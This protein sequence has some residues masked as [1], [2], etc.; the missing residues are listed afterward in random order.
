MSISRGKL[1]VVDIHSL[2]N[3]IQNF[4]VQSAVERAELL[5][6]C[7]RL[8][9]S[10]VG[11]YCYPGTQDYEDCVQEAYIGLFTAVE[12]FDAASGVKFT[13][14]ATT[15]MN[16]R[17]IDYLASQWKHPPNAMAEGANFSADG[18]DT[19]GETALEIDDGTYEAFETERIWAIDADRLRPA[20]RSSIALLPERQREAIHLF[21]F[22]GLSKAEVAER[23]QVSRPRATALVGDAVLGLRRRM[24]LTV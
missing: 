11:K 20:L 23:M 1:P 18:Q 8:V 9:H 17:I 19:T 2:V 21:Y 22:E 7:E 4:P 6:A 13:T 10:R 16:R 15:V 24:N 5:G 14:F 3:H 12:K